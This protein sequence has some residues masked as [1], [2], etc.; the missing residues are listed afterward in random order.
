MKYKNLGI[1]AIWS[2]DSHERVARQ[3][4]DTAQADPT[5]AIR[6]AA[7]VLEAEPSASLEAQSVALRALALAR[8]EQG[9]P[10]VARVEISAAVEIARA[11]GARG[12]VAEAMITASLVQLACGDGAS[13]RACAD[14]AVDLS[15][16]PERSRAQ[17]QRALILQRLGDT[18]DALRAYDSVIPELARE[19]DELWLCRALS[20][21]GVLRMYRNELDAADAD[22]REARDRALAIGL[23]VAA[24][25]CE[26]NLGCIATRRGEIHVALA[27]F[28]NAQRLCERS[29]ATTAMLDADRCEA[30]LLGGLYADAVDAA[31]RAVESLHDVGAMAELAEAELQLSRAYAAAARPDDA[32]RAAENA[33]RRFHEQGRASWAFVA[34]GV[35]MESDG[36]CGDWP[37]PKIDE[38]LALAAELERKGWH[39]LAL[40]IQ[41]ACAASA[42]LLDDSAYAR[43]LY[44]HARRLPRNASIDHRILAASATVHLHRL[45]G[46]RAL[47]RA[48][49]TRGT[50]LLQLQRDTMGSEELRAGLAQRHRRLADSGLRLER[51]LGDPRTAIRCADALVDDRIAVSPPRAG[52]HAGRTE[53]L[54]E[55]RTLR[56]A[57]HSASSP[58]PFS[59]MRRATLLESALLAQERAAVSIVRERRSSRSDMPLSPPGVCVVHVAAEGADVVVRVAVARSA[60]E[61]ALPAHD[62]HADV[63]DLIHA[64]SELAGAPADHPR[65][66]RMQRAF[67][68]A[69]STA[70][71]RL[72]S[73]IA[74]STAG[75]PLLIVPGP[76]AAL[77]WGLVPGFAET[78]FSIVDSLRRPA[79]PVVA[80]IGARG[81]ALLVGGPGLPHS[82][83]E[84]AEI[85][86]LRPGSLVRCGADATVDAVLDGL[87]QTSIAHFAAHGSFRLDN[88]LFSALYLHD[89]PLHA[90]E[91]S[92]LA[93]APAIVVLASCA[94][95]VQHGSVGGATGFASALLRVGAGCVIAPLL[96]VEDAASMDA[97][98]AMHRLLVEGVTAAD[99]L[100]RLRSRADSGSSFNRAAASFAAFGPLGLAAGIA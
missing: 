76:L 99:A 44:N 69:R 21:R 16:G 31:E 13:A 53:L 58:D 75:R 86:G 35:A 92:A 10:N 78:P 93:S 68:I 80:K 95:G 34:R 70:S 79:P 55:L 74:G 20:N 24:A 52:R 85:A 29:G 67:E 54:V 26:Q 77:P 23:D 2:P 14:E 27:T 8:V 61:F 25:R 40:G 37:R 1:P 87:S 36:I 33:E 5:A 39:E 57:L 50:R 65:R 97:M 22:L 9:E 56:S 98:I 63:E 81:G 4:L 51:A 94:A 49:F 38:A 48:A 3:A 71:A 100:C 12:L 11:A 43:G 30:L 42:E 62:V 47:G 91:L 19:H 45:D 96:D 15:V 66:D 73:P 59:A 84:I 41:L 60:E 28:D 90:Y 18:D 7:A 89:G 72:W 32:A 83:T 17:A 46:A 64:A 88:P 82:N 6:M